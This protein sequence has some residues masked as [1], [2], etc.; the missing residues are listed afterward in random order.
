MILSDLYVSNLIKEIE[1]KIINSKIFEVKRSSYLSSSL[2]FLFDGEFSYG[3]GLNKYNVVLLENEFNFQIQIKNELI[4]YF[5]RLYKR[6]SRIK[7]NRMNIYIDNFQIK[8]VDSD[9]IKYIEAID[10]IMHK[11]KQISK[12]QLNEDFIIPNLLFFIDFISFIY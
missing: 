8:N 7:Y 12:L 9:D 3:Y 6:I 11:K 5:S 4:I 1:S 2:K 10:F